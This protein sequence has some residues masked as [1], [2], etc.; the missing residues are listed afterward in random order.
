MFNNTNIPSPPLFDIKF[1]LSLGINFFGFFIGF[2][3]NESHHVLDLLLN[4]C[5]AES[6]LESLFLSET[7]GSY[8]I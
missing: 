7:K 8:I 4:I 1:F 6:H 2:L 5:V 3:L